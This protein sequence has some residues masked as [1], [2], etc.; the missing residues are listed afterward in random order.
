MRPPNGTVLSFATLPM[1]VAGV[2]AAE[3]YSGLKVLKVNSETLLGA[4]R[5]Y[6][7]FPVGSS[8]PSGQF[9]AQITI[10]TADAG[11]SGSIS[12]IQRNSSSAQLSS[13]TVATGIVAAITKPTVYKV[14]G[15]T[16]EAGAAF[17]D[18][19]VSL[20]KSAGDKIRSFRLRSMLLA[21]GSY[22][23][24]RRPPIQTPAPPILPT[25]SYFPNT[26][27]TS[28]G[29]SLYNASTSTED[30]EIVLSMGAGDTPQVFY[31]V[32]AVGVFAPANTITFAAM[33]YS[34]AAG[35]SASADVGI[36]CLDSNGSIINTT[37][38]DSVE[39]ANT[40]DSLSVSR[41][42]PAN[43]AVVRLRFVRRTGVALAKFKRPVVTSNSFF[44]NVINEGNTAAAISGSTF[45]TVYVRAALG[46]SLVRV[47]R[48]AALAT[49]APATPGQ[50]IWRDGPKHKGR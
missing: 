20:N 30:G 41:L 22:S 35:P 9:S 2:Q 4:G 38:I 39:T 43:A 36:V 14:E 40:W 3:V 48:V 44:A 5:I 37:Q 18:F 25:I 10:E 16:L 49:A 11:S 12:L 23:G 47:A 1:L 45:K 21:D 13:T 50:D 8:F 32:P 6:W 46:R 29:A 42:I 28:A 26:S 33:A 15:I 27:L 34:S 24:F 7:R 17:I 31:D 19:D